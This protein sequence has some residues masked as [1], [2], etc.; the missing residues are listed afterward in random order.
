MR[1]N[2][3]VIISSRTLRIFQI[4]QAFYSKYSYQLSHQHTVAP[5]NFYIFGS[6]RFR[7]ENPTI[8]CARLI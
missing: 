6:S 5:V 3:N 8:P 4:D 7:N 2:S 1:E